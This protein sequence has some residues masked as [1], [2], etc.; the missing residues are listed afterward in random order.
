MS[1]S[2]S[3][4]TIRVRVLAITSL[5][6]IAG[7]VGFY[8][9]VLADETLRFFESLSLMLFVVL[10]GWIAFSFSMALEGFIGRITRTRRQAEDDSVRHWDQIGSSNAV[11]VPVYNESPKRVFAAV[12]AMR[13]QLVAKRNG[14]DRFDF[15]IL[16]DTTDPDVWLQ[17]EWCWSELVRQFPRESEQDD[18]DSAAIHVYYRHRTHNTARKAGNIADFC[19]NWGG[20][21]DHMIVLDADSLMTGGTMIEMVR[22]MKGDDRLGILQVPP[23]PVGRASL[24]ARWQQFSAAVYGPMFAEGFDRFAGDQGNYWG[25]NAIIRVSAF[26]RHCQLPVLPGPAP[27]GGEILSHDFVEASLLVRAGWKVKIANDLGGSYEECPTTILDFVKRDQRWCQGNLQHWQVMTAAGIHPISRI[28]FLSGMLSY[29]AAP[30][31]MIFL[32]TSVVAAVVNEH[33]GQWPIAGD[34]TTIM[35]GL[36][37]GS[38]G[39]L[40]VPK[41]LALV[42]A[43]YESDRRRSLGGAMRLLM[44]VLVET[45]AS[46]LF[47]PIIAVYHTR[48]VIS[49]LTGHNVQWNAQQRD[50]SGV[51]WG[52]ATAQMWPL[53]VA[54]IA[55]G[56]SLGIARPEWLGWFSPFVLGW[57]L[58]IPIAVAMGSRR[59]GVGML[60]AGL[61]QIASERQPL[62]I[63]ARHQHWIAEI[64]AWQR[65]EA[66]EHRSL[67]DRFLSDESFRNQHLAI[68]RSAGNQ[69][70]VQE[71]E[72]E[73][74]TRCGTAAAVLTEPASTRRRLLSDDEWIESVELKT[75]RASE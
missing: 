19:E 47:A 13:E 21:Y 44:S 37:I 51:S 68:L 10:F 75:R 64:E 27:L 26:M 63:L 7:C 32:A 35:L 23:V 62:S 48:F 30:I 73:W 6:W 41:F 67:L 40:V 29:L 69:S 49:V 38:M 8:R 31:W 53:S 3:A 33:F 71:N 17:E 9:V 43:I 46:V 34:G 20:H 60:H 45:F 56:L 22:R 42:V 57:A 28:H 16:S 4:N 18:A 25:H 50:E 1:H 66:Y 24:F 12:A 72:P 15:Y 61:L 14:V 70:P 36:F 2:T 52:E 55:L 39:L 74:R 58:S 5:I 11:L 65:D 54:G 59:L